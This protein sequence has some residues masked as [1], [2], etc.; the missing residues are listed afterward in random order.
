M[1]EGEN[2]IPLAMTVGLSGKIYL[3][4]Q[5]TRGVL[6][7]DSDGNYSHWL[8]PKDK[9]FSEDPGLMK[10]DDGKI[11]PSD[12]SFSSKSEKVARGEEEPGL[13]MR[14]LL[15]QD[16]LPEIDVGMEEVQTQEVIDV[17]VADITIDSAGQIYILSEETSKIYVYSHTEEFLYSFGQKGGSTGKMSR[18]K[19][20]V[21][22]EV[23]KA[24]YIVDYMR[25][26]IL[27]FN[28]AGKFMYEFGGMGTGPGWFQFPVSLALGKAGHL[29]VADLFN[30][31]VQVLDVKFEYKFPWLY[32]PEKKEEKPLPQEPSQPE[33]GEDILQPFPIIL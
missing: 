8:K 12:L 31:R 6:V 14:E 10:R 19:S 17:Q 15:P 26:T 23:K 24:L 4:G 11:L 16:L 5:N 33:E 21:V 27:I 20:I 25:H 2:F 7:L 22:D 29:I 32:S 18:P 9:L 1:P 3:V 30:Q 13:D 28:L